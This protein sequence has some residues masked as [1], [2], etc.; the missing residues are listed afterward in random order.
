[1]NE[2]STRTLDEIAIG[3]GTD[4][5]SLNHNYMKLYSIYFGPIRHEKLKIFEIGIDKGFSLK[6]WKEYFYNSEITG[7]DI[8]DL[9]HMEED[10]VNV[11]LGDQKDEK[12]LNEVNKSYGPF[13]IIIDDGSHHN[14][15]MKASF[16]CLFPLLKPGGLYIIEDLHACYWGKSHGTGEPVFIDVLK[17]LI[18]DINSRGKSGVADIRKDVDDTLYNL[19]ENSNPTWWEKNVEFMHLYRGIVFIK[20]YPPLEEKSSLSESTPVYLTVTPVVPLVHWDYF[21][22]KL[23]VKTR[24]HLKRLVF[25][26]LN[27]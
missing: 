7:I 19:K 22:K 21:G 2:K 24:K 17:K 12:I 27:K 8:L 26:V 6:T 20:K 23:W 4:K 9:K 1:M 18:D 16:E 14:D 3:Y 15:D 11:V 13:D 10:R 25:K 5:S